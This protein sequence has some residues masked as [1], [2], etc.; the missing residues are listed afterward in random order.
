[1]RK[2]QWKHQLLK[3]KVPAVEVEAGAELAVAGEEVSPAEAAAEATETTP[4]GEG[5]TEE[6]SLDEL[7]A[8][9]PEIL[10]AGATG[11]EEEEGSTPASKD[12][13]K[14]K[15]KYVEVVLRSGSRHHHRP[16]DAQA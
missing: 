10:V 11:E 13:K 1:M 2:W 9:K 7:F 16:Q 4:A 15:K 6:V 8:L 12:K 5:E 14:K 3:Q